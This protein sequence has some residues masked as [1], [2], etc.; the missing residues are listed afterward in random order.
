MGLHGI[1]VSRLLCKRQYG[2]PLS[3][4]LLLSSAMGWEGVKLGTQPLLHNLSV[5]LLL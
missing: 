1:T 3:V 5:A 4:T 2:L